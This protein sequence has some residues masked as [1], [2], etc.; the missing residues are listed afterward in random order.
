[1][2]E[3]NKQIK[4]MLT[5]QMRLKYIKLDGVTL[6]NKKAILAAMDKLDT[7]E[8]SPNWNKSRRMAMKMQ[9]KRVMAQKA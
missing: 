6:N 7:T 4:K 2:R 5:P 9:M 8:K 1:M 3:L